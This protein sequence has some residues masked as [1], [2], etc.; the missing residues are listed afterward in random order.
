VLTPSQK[1][2]I[3]EAAI[4]AAAVKLGVGVYRPVNEGLPC[5]LIF[6]I[7]GRLL[8]VQCKW[9]VRRGDVVVITCRTCRRTRNGYLRRTYTT[10]DVDAI[11]AYCPEIDACYLVPIDHFPGRPLISLRLQ[12]T[13][14]NQRTGVNWASDYEL[15]GTLASLQ[16]P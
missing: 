1:G 6:D 3:A 14:N 2:S 4:V 13:R 8:R 15:A 10:D 11:A 16:G 7:A 5:D 12:P 9:V